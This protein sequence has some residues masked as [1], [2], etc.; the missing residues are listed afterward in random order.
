MTA[1][2]CHNQADEQRIIMLAKDILYCASHSRAKI[3][4]HVSMA[5]S[6]R[7]L[8]GSKGL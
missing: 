7:H 6:L 1:P 8:T 4:K 2:E 3:L 5:M